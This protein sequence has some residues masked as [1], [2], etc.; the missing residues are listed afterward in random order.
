[1]NVFVTLR[2]D[3]VLLGDVA[4][5]KRTVFA[6]RSLERLIDLIRRRRRTLAMFAIGGS[7]GPGS[8]LGILFWLALGERRCLPLARALG[9][10]ELRLEPLA[11]GLETGIALLQFAD[12]TLSL[13]AARANERGHTVTLAERPGS[14]L[15]QFP[16]ILLGICS[17]WTLHKNNHL[18]SRNLPNNFP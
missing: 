13:S 18:K 9:F 10:V 8:R 3:L 14:Q 4:A 5:A 2:I 15:R 6:Q 16:Y 7:L 17:R 12:A 1:V 11:F